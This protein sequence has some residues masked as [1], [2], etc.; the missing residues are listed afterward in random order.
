[1]AMG[2]HYTTVAAVE[3]AVR[4]AIERDSKRA[5]R[6][7]TWV[8]CEPIGFFPEDQDPDGKLSGFS[9]LN[10]FPTPEE[11]VE[12]GSAGRNANDV[13]F[14]VTQLCRWSRKYG[15][16][17]QLRFESEL[18]GTITDGRCEARLQER[19][20]GLASLGEALGEHFGEETDEPGGPSLRIWDEPQAD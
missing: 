15:L 17:W 18:L 14:L 13:R 5:N 7:Q 4:H 2:L 16:V 3:P 19:I 1:M 12:A 6:R 20:D 9:K 11:L 10:L 8:L